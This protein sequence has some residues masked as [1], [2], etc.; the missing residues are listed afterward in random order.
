MNKAPK[1][2]CKLLGVN[3]TAVGSRYDGSEIDRW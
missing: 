1:K 2:L 3:E